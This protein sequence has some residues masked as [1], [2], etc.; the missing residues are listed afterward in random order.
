M[1][2]IGIET[3][4]CAAVSVVDKVPVK[5]L[6]ETLKVAAPAVVL[7]RGIVTVPVCPPVPFALKVPVEV[8]LPQLNVQ[9]AT[10]ALTFT[11]GE[12]LPV[13]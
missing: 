1:K 4:A 6:P 10:C 2:V 5:P 9:V 8:P 7:L 12:Q 3:E 13:A 11:E